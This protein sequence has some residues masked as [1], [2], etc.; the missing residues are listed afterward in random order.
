MCSGNKKNRE[1]DIRKI[2]ETTD[3][4]FTGNSSIDKRRRVAVI[5]QRKD[6]GALAVSKIHSKDGKTSKRFIEGLVLYPKDHTSLTKDSV[7]ESKV[8]I[9][10]KNGQG[11]FNPIYARDL[12]STNDRLTKKEHRAARRGAGGSTKKN[13]QTHKRKIRNWRNHF[14]K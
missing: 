2:Y 4:Y 1:S 14:G 6:D 9:G 13:K 8:H 12:V 5:E 10:V 11:S 7:M 3:G